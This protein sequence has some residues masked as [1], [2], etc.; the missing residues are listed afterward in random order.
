MTLPQSILIV[1]LLFSQHVGNI[2]PSSLTLN[3]ENTDDLMAHVLY[4]NV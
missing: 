1:Y 3:K 2:Y 4:L